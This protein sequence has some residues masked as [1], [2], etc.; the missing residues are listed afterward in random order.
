MG[1]I[2]RR[3]GGILRGAP[4]LSK[5]S[6]IEK[7]KDINS[8]EVYL[9]TLRCSIYPIFS[10]NISHGKDSSSPLNNTHLPSFEEKSKYS[11]KTEELSSHSTTCVA[12]GPSNIQLT[13]GVVNEFAKRIIERVTLFSSISANS[14]ISAFKDSATYLCKELFGTQTFQPSLL[15]DLSGLYLLL[16][17]YIQKA[18][19]DLKVTNDEWD[20]IFFSTAELFTSVLKESIYALEP[21]SSILSHKLFKESGYK[22]FLNR[23]QKSTKDVVGSDMLKLSDWVRVLFDIDLEQHN[24]CLMEQKKFCSDRVRLHS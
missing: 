8:T 4:R 9:A 2:L 6:Q 24:R 20:S 18:I 12:L 15:T 3:R 7:R 16:G 17:N 21:N 5:F 19:R 10:D 22:Q 13:P 1:D 11:F 23:W 14:R